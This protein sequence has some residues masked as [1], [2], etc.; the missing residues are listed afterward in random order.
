MVTTKIYNEGMNLIK[1]GTDQQLLDWIYV[2]Q[3]T[4]SPEDFASIK[5]DPDV[6]IAKMNA[7]FSPARILKILA[8]GITLVSAI[9]L[10]LILL[11]ATVL[12]VYEMFSLTLASI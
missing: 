3:K 1:N 10:F 11:A 8:M 7:K 5:M 12:I 2:Q 6:L 9:S 4:L